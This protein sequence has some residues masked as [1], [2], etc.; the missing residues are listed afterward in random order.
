M[1]ICFLLQNFKLMNNTKVTELIKEAF[2]QG[3]RLAESDCGCAKGLPVSEE[4]I[5]RLA[6]FYV[7]SKL[8]NESS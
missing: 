7:K 2:K 6:N 8:T 5:E 4:F 3:Y 1:Y